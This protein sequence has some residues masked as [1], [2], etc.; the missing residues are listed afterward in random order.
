MLLELKTYK[1][2]WFTSDNSSFFKPYEEILEPG[3]YLLEVWGAK[4]GDGL[5]ESTFK[6]GGNG[7]YSRGFLNLAEKTKIFIYLGGKGQ[8]SR[9]ESS[10]VAVKVLGGFN[11]GGYNYDTRPIDGKASGGGATDIRILEDSLYHRVIVAGGG[12]GANSGCSYG[13]ADGGAGGGFE[14]CKSPG[15]YGGCSGLINKTDGSGGTQISGG[16]MGLPTSTI[17]IAPQPNG[18]FGFGGNV[19]GHNILAGGGGG[20]WYGGGA[21]NG[22]DGAG[23]G[24][25]GFALNNITYQYVPQNYKLNSKYFLNNAKLI[26]GEHEVPSF[27]GDGNKTMIGNPDNGHARISLI[28]PKTL[29]IPRKPKTTLKRFLFM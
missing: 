24:G 28:Y 12:G 3:S 29:C 7:G 14:G 16:V 8:T 27:F 17:N 15:H 20:G 13:Y 26:D 2:F 9:N 11:G 25:S 10:T 4:G 22:H 6:P 5:W 18:T 21:G 1:D 19:E 23:G